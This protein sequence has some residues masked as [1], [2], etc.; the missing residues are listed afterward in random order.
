M[1]NPPK[2]IYVAAPYRAA[3]PWKTEQNI[4]VAEAAA[5][6]VAKLGAYPVCPHTNTRGYFESAQADPIFWLGGT[7]SLMRRCDGVVLVAGWDRSE[8]ARLEHETALEMGMPVFYAIDQ[9]LTD[10]IEGPTT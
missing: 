8:G 1:K 10:F 3:D 5:Y 4:R 7:L 2:L 9:R 6:E